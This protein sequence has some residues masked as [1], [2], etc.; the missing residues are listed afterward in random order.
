MPTRFP[1]GRGRSTGRGPRADEA[2]FERRPH[3]R[4]PALRRGLRAGRPL[5]GSA[6]LP[7]GALA[8]ERR[9]GHGGRAVHLDDAGHLSRAE[10]PARRI[11][12]LPRGVACMG[13]PGA[14]AGQPPNRRGARLRALGHQGG[15]PEVRGHRGSLQQ[16]HPHRE[17]R[18]RG[19]PRQAQ[20]QEAGGAAPKRPRHRG[21]RRRQDLEVLHT[22]HP[23][24]ERGLLR[25]RLEGHAAAA[26]RQRAGG[27]R[28]RDQLHEPGAHV[29]FRRREPLLAHPRRGGD[30]RVRG[31][32]HR[33][34]H[35]RQ[36]PRGRPV[37]GAGRAAALHR[38]H[39]LPDVLLPARGPQLRRAR[40][41]ALAGTGQGGR[42]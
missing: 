20:G 21:H 40:H 14:I 32:L 28:L 13:L 1:I 16:R 9:R 18:A 10:R 31:V 4:R 17:L 15:G 11:H 29:G 12:L 35:R 38:P 23:A 3:C 5:G 39:R 2:L 25:H 30:H 24:D 22:Q 42:R 34:H 26:A 6:P 37:L 33:E 27:E 19:R 36:G 8:A 7:G 41:A